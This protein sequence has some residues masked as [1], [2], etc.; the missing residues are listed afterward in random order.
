MYGPH[1]VDGVRAMVL[2]S[3]EIAP[4]LDDAWAAVS[5]PDPERAW[6]APA[7]PGPGGIP[8]LLVLR[9]PPVRWAAHATL[10][11]DPELVTVLRSCAARSP[12]LLPVPAPDDPRPETATELVRRALARSLASLWSDPDA[13][14][15]HRREV[16]S[17]ARAANRLGRRLLRFDAARDVEAGDG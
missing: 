5:G 9:S 11:G 17:A 2:G 6:R 13:D 7:P 12:L 15:A 1:F 16:V 3:G 4:S 8:G 14:D 10:A